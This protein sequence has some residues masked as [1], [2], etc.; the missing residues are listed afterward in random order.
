MVVNKIYEIHL[1][2]ITEPIEVFIEYKNDLK[3]SE[4]LQCR[5]GWNTKVKPIRP[6]NFKRKIYWYRIRSRCF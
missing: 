4:R 5:E 3:Q 2:N 1:N 6:Q